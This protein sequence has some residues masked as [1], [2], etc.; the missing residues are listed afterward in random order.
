MALI[1][2]EP[3]GEVVSQA[4]DEGATISAVNLS[5]V[6][7]KLADAGATEALIRTAL[8]RL[9]LDVVAF[10]AELAYS[11]GLL[12]PQTRQAGLSLGDRAC[13]ALARRLA[14]EVITTD[15]AWADLDVE[16]AVRV[17][18]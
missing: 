16:V 14:A 18:R 6:I 11:A 1:Q 4:I 5:E 7:A 3:G 12:R 10:D 2:H 8:A 17:A 13:L 15:R 9:N